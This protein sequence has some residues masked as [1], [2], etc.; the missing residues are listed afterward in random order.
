M[1]NIRASYVVSQVLLVTTTSVVINIAAIGG[2][3]AT[4]HAT[5]VIKASAFV[6]PTTTLEN[7]IVTLSDFRQIEVGKA[8]I[9]IATITEDV[10]ISFDTSFTDSV[11]MT[12]AVNRMFYGNID[13]DPTDPDADPDPIVMADTDAKSVDKVLDDASAVTDTDV[14]S[15]GKVASDSVTT[16]EE[17]NTKDVGKSLADAAT[18]ADNINTF[19]TDKVVADSATAT[20]AAAKDF[21]RPN[22]I[23]SVTAADD[24]SRQPELGKT[25]SVTAADTFGPFDIGV[26]PSDAATATD[27]VNKFDVTTVLADSVSMTDF[28]AKTPGYNFDFDVVDADAD[29]D[30]VTMADV[31]AKEFTRPDITDAASIADSPALQVETPRTD[32]V[33]TADSDAK[34]FD[35]ARSESVAATDAAA[36]DTSKVLTDATSGATDLMLFTPNKVATDTVS[37]TDVLNLFAV[38]AVLA[39]SVSMA[40]SIATLL[41]LGQTTPIYPDYVSMADGNGFVFHR[42]KAKVPNY[43]EVLGGAD[44][45]LNSDYMQSASDSHTHENYTG[46]ING[47]GLLLT[48]PLISGEFITYADTS[49]AGLVVNFHYTDAADRTVGG[50]RFN[51]TPIL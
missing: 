29:P 7:E 9:E 34:S 21:T 30:P 32:A 2:A 46:L 20:D 19:N 33:T 1:A 14:K 13:F 27:A 39:D 10:A 50:Y 3:T 48:A 43:T 45:L 15:T 36:L 44:S 12:D 49:G 18:A 42:Y 31:M 8:I 26:N 41:V 6:V 11:T 35:T 38:S 24:S 40:D 16:A 37:A 28:I 47:P 25:D 5:P 17:I 22:L 4:A 51:E 23:D